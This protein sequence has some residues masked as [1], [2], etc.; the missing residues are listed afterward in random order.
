[1]HKLIYKH[2][3]GFFLFL[4]ESWLML[5][6]ELCIDGFGTTKQFGRVFG[7]C[8]TRQ[9][10]LLHRF[11][12]RSLELGCKSL[13]CGQIYVR[14]WW[15]II[16]LV[17]QQC[18]PLYIQNSAKPETPTSIGFWDKSYD[19]WTWALQFPC[20]IA[21]RTPALEF[22]TKIVQVN[23]LLS[24]SWKLIPLG[25]LRIQIVLGLQC[26]VDWLI[27]NTWSFRMGYYWRCGLLYESLDQVVTLVPFD[28]LIKIWQHLIMMMPTRVSGT[29]RFLWCIFKLFSAREE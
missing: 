26:T 14:Q 28:I 23:P 29:V 16:S 7:G 25:C 10:F 3:T 21:S 27:G 19:L 15:P 5:V 18:L 9:N 13:M 17:V 24:A 11:Y 12:V 1:M 22:L 6:S 8:L 4:F 20:K 2:K